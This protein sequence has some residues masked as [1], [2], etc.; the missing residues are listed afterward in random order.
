MLLLPPTTADAKAVNINVQRTQFPNFSAWNKPRQVDRPLTSINQSSP[1]L[2]YLFPVR[3]ICC[4]LAHRRLAIHFSTSTSYF[5]IVFVSFRLFFF[6]FSSFIV[7][8]WFY[9]SFFDSFTFSLRIFALSFRWSSSNLSTLNVFYFK[10]KRRT[11][12]TERLIHFGMPPIA[13]FTEKYLI[14]IIKHLLGN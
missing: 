14:V 1:C 5:R 6:A 9:H 7:I 2:W 11:N 13:S 3:L 12:E 10:V 4:Y 8:F